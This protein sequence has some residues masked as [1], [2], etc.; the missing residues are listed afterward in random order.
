M[1]GAGA[2]V[3]RATFRRRHVEDRREVGLHAGIGIH[4]GA[5]MVGAIGRVT[6][7]AT[8]GTQNHFVALACASFGDPLG[9]VDQALFAFQA[10][11][12]TYQ[13]LDGNG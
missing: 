8:G 1:E 12:R 7:V 6:Q 13:N 9:D 10:L 4:F 3:A 5:S 11:F 2:F